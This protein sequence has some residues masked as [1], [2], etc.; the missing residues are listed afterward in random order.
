MITIKI[1][2]GLGNQLFQYAFGYALSKEYKDDLFLDIEFYDKQYKYVGIRKFNLDM[3][4]CNTKIASKRRGI[5]KI[6]ESFLVNRIIHR[7]KP[8]IV[9][10]TKK[11]L[12]VKER[13]KEYFSISEPVRGINNYYDG[14]WQTSLYFRKYKL[15]LKEQFKYNGK[16]ND[17][18]KYFLN[19]IQNSNSVSVHIRRGDFVSSKRIGHLIDL[20]YYIRA[21]DYICFIVSDPVFFIFS[22]DLQWVRKNLKSS[23]S[24]EYVDNKCNDSEIVDMMLMTECKHGIMSASTFSWWGNW[25]K[26]ADENTIIV[27]PRGKYFNNRFI[28]DN[29]IVM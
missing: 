8:E 24:L 15:E 14:Y 6:L 11:N 21:M 18:A 3:L 10:R 23:Y 26:D 19:K 28:E 13:K 20:E 9:F 16:Y 7:Y 5:I 1:W 12:F 25:L 4:K 22:D 2:G 29:W 27:A 17:S